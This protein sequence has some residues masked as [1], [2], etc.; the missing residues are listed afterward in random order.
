MFL[1]AIAIP[2]LGVLRE[3]VEADAHIRR[4]KSTKANTCS[5]RFCRILVSYNVKKIV[6]FVDQ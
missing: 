5:E 6:N 4:N 3:N 2:N 1:D